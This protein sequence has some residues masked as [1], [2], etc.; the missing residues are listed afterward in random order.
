MHKPPPCRRRQKIKGVTLVEVMYASFIALTCCL[1][2]AATV[3]VANRSRGRAEFISIATSL[4]QKQLESIKGLGYAK[5][6]SDSLV[7]AGIVQSS[8]AVDLKA[9]GLTSGTESGYETTNFD[10]AQRDTALNAL[11]SG[12]SFVQLSTVDIDLKQATIRVFWK[13][14]GQV[15]STMVSS[16]VANL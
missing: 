15:R 6:T 12:R 3:P 8:T 14:N 13:D 5:L 7:T 2:F 9:A 10:L 1:L 4:A 11:P 16:L